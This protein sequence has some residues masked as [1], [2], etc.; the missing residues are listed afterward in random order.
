[1]EAA[2]EDYFPGCHPPQPPAPPCFLACDVV[3]FTSSYVRKP[4][5]S[6]LAKQAPCIDIA[7]YTRCVVSKFNDRAAD[8]RSWLIFV[9][10]ALH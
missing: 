8:G 2:G 9:L 3:M 7:D 10:L 4:L 6:L 1:M 5:H